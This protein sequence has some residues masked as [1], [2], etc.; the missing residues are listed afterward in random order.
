MYEWKWIAANGV[1]VTR[2]SLGAD[3]AAT[4]QQAVTAWDMRERGTV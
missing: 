4:P 2:E 3:E 1:T